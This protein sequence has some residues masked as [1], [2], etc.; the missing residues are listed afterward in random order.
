VLEITIPQSDILGAHHQ[1]AVACFRHEDGCRSQCGVS[2]LIARKPCAGCDERHSLMHTRSDGRM[3]RLS[4]NPS[5]VRSCVGSWFGT[6]VKLFE[7]TGS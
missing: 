4:C 1:G 5:C 6:R 2:S 3:H 7:G